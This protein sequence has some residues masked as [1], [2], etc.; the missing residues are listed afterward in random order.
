MTTQIV[1]LPGGIKR[2]VKEIK[3]DEKSGIKKLNHSNYSKLI[4]DFKSNIECL[5]GKMVHGKDY[6]KNRVCSAKRFE[7]N[8]IFNKNNNESKVQKKISMRIR[9]NLE[10]SLKV[11]K[12]VE[13]TK[14]RR[15][16]G[17]K[18]AFESQINFSKF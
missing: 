15:P 10:P 13:Q 5:P 6:E 7:T 12:F 9:N 18:N 16:E 14:C 8:D 1:N 17:I 3:D 2:N 11:K 4:K